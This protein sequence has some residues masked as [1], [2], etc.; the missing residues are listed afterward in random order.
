MTHRPSV[1]VTLDRIGDW[2]TVR[3]A[4][5]LDLDTAPALL[6]AV[7]GV[8]DALPQPLLIFDLRE[9]SFMDGS[10]LGILV[11]AQEPASGRR[12][13]VVV[14]TEQPIVLM[15][16]SLSGADGSFLVY[17]DEEAFVASLDGNARWHL[18]A[19]ER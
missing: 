8:A 9:V 2:P 14:I 15:V 7:A 11:G 17:P 18:S 6:R 16:L 3:V 1:R 10:G 12:R 13:E 5:E 4:G 19:G